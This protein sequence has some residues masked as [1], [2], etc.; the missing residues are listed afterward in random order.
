MAP[1]RQ[2]APQS[3]FFEGGR[4]SSFAMEHRPLSANVAVPTLDNELHRSHLQPTSRSSL[5]GPRNG[6]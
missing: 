1:G 5:F 6:G 4:N 2:K 3:R